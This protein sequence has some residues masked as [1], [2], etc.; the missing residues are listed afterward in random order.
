MLDPVITHLGPI[1]LRWYGVLVAVGALMGFVL[2][3]LRAK[4]YSLSKDH[5]GDLL[6]ISMISAIVGAR[7]FYVVRFWRESFADQPFAEVFKVWNGGLVFQG[8]FIIAAIVVIAYLVKKKIPIGNAGDDI[9]PALPLA[10]GIGRIGCL[11]NGC[12]YGFHPY[13]GPFACTYSHVEGSCFPAQAV[14]SAGNFLLCG[15]LLLLE[16]KNIAKSKLF[17]IYMIGYT[18]LRFAVEPLRGDYPLDQRW[19]GMTPGQY[20]ALWQLPLFVALFFACTAWR[21]AKKN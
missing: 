8:G 3:N 14:E 16:K 21:K 18:V 17:I 11:L 1:Q 4:K 6:L 5:L 12:C 10:H 9:A 19:C 13:N 15:I 20:H 2:M 7:L